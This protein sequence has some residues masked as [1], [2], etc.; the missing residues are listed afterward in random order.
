ME[1]MVRSVCLL[2]ALAGCFSATANNSVSSVAGTER[3]LN[4]LVSELV[5]APLADGECRFTLKKAGWVYVAFDRQHFGSEAFLD[6]GKAPVVAFRGDELSETMRYLDAGT[7]TIRVAGAP[8][9]GALVC[10]G[11]E[12]YG[13]G[14]QGYGR[15]R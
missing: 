1:R 15:I 6:G 5:D 14:N 2:W 3:K 13:S 11:D 7:H 12:R 9:C 4:N 8:K 10:A